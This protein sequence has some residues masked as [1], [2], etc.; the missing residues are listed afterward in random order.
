MGQG[1]FG[2][3]NGVSGAFHTFTRKA[4]APAVPPPPPHAVTERGNGTGP[5]DHLHGFNRALRAMRVEGRGP[6]LTSLLLPE[7]IFASWTEEFKDAFGDRALLTN[8]WRTE[9]PPVC[10][11]EQ[12]GRVGFTSV[13]PHLVSCPTFKFL[14]TV[15]K[16]TR[17]PPCPL[18]TEPHKLRGCPV[19]R[20]SDLLQM[21]S[22]SG[23]SS[24]RLLAPRPGNTLPLHC[25][26][27]SG[28]CA[29]GLS[30]LMA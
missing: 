5:L 7:L 26:L 21:C 12:T 23:D 29:F 28:L 10:V 18:Y 3:L 22:Q 2:V 8:Q 11:A 9:P 6:E 16:G 20:G 25:I 4:V 15:S 24:P 13:R 17:T 14:M 19:Y 27:P 30:L 1:D